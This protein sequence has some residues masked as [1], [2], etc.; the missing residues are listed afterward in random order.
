M[1]YMT[2]II[3]ASQDYMGL[4]WVLYDTALQR[5]AALTGNTG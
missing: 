2:T 5:Q 4:A 1:A 3:R